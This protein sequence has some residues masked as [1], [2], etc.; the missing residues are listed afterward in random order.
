MYVPPTKVY[1]RYRRDSPHIIRDPVLPILFLPSST[2]L[3]SPE[4]P[5]V[6]CD[7]KFQQKCI[8]EL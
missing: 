2:W 5:E 6:W 7:R 1:N 8:D 4:V 3:P